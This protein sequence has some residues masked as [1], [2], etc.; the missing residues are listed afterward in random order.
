MRKKRV[1]KSRLKLFILRA[2]RMDDGS[3]FHASGP[4]VQ[5]TRMIVPRQQIN[6][7]LN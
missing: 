2:E 1:F 5:R 6:I 4:L 3:W 7:L